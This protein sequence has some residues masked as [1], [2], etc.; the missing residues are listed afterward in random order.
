MPTTTFTTAASHNNA[1]YVKQ[2]PAG[3]GFSLQLGLDIR[4]A[5][6]CSKVSEANLTVRTN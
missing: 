5:S 3:L 4:S 6:S 2:S 1:A